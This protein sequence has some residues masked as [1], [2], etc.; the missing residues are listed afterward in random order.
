MSTSNTTAKKDEDFWALCHANGLTQAD[1][2]QQNQSKK[3][4]IGRTGIEK[5]QGKNNIHISLNVEAAGLDFAIVKAT[6]S[7]TVKPEG[8]KAAKKISVETLGSAQ[9]SNSKVTY[10]AELAEKRAKGRAV[11]MLLGFY[12]LGVYGEDEADEFARPADQPPAAAPVPTPEPRPSPPAA[13]EPA[14]PASVAPAPYVTP[15]Q[16]GEAEAEEWLAKATVLSVIKEAE[17]LEE[18]QKIWVGE[19]KQL[20]KDVDVYAAKEAR[21]K[22]LQ[23]NQTLAA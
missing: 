6:A 16:N 19:A 14:P 20:Q 3:W 9:K 18:L 4:I 11:L 5:I 1:V 2:W 13:P 15:D 7:R 12:K 17:T 21:K 22:H 8:A 23:D 10:Y